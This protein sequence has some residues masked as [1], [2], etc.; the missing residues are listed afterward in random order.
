MAKRHI[1]VLSAVVGVIDAVNRIGYLLEGLRELRQAIDDQTIAGYSVIGEDAHRERWS[2]RQRAQ[3]RR[4]VELD[5]EREAAPPELVKPNVDAI[6]QLIGNVDENTELTPV[7]ILFTYERMKAVMR[8]LHWAACDRLWG[9]PVLCLPP[10]HEGMDLYIG[11]V[12]QYEGAQ[13]KTGVFDDY[14]VGGPGY[15]VG[16]RVALDD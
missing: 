1:T 7:V 9:L 13:I 11:A 4:E 10:D 12:P 6:R 14:L 2:A 15:R 8:E 5:A 3:R 16:R